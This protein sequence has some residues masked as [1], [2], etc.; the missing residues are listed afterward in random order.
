MSAAKSIRRFIFSN[1]NRFL[2]KYKKNI[3]FCSETTEIDKM[4]KVVNE[5]EKKE[6]KLYGYVLTFFDENTIKEDNF[7]TNIF[8]I[9]PINVSISAK[10]PSVYFILKY[11]LQFLQIRHESFPLTLV[12]NDSSSRTVVNL[13]PSGHGIRFS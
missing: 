4:W 2:Q 8:N 12:S 6:R 1:N 7:Y 10:C 11:F 5:I 13:W 3:I 9:C